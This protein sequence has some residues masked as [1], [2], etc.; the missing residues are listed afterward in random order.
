MLLHS[1][2]NKDDH[3]LKFDRWKFYFDILSRYGDY[4]LK[5]KHR[6]HSPQ[7]GNRG[8]LEYV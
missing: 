6:F 5:I 8:E 4:F 3:K 1:S 7:N 2:K